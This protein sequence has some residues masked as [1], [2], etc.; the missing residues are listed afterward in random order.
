MD[1]DWAVHPA[2]DRLKPNTLYQVACDAGG[3]RTKLP[4]TLTVRTG[5]QQEPFRYRSMR[6]G[7]SLVNGEFLP[8]LAS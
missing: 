6:D 2:A 7:V 4:Q 3:N 1:L 5:T 8:D